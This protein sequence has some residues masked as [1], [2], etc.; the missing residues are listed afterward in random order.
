MGFRE[1]EEMLISDRESILEVVRGSSDSTVPQ[2]SVIMSAYNAERF[3]AQ[4]IESILAQTFGDFELIIVNDGSRDTTQEIIERY[5][6]QDRRIAPQSLPHNAGINHARNVGLS[7]ANGTYIALMDADD[8]SLPERFE[9]QVRFLDRHPEVGIVGGAMIIV[10]ENNIPIGERR[11]PTN[12]ASIRQRLFYYC[13]FCHPCIMVR[14]NVVLLTGSYDVQYRGTADYDL[15]FRIGMMTRFANLDDVLLHYRVSPGSYS[16]LQKKRMEMETIAI[17]R[18]YFKTY[19]NSLTKRMYH[20]LHTLSLF[21]IPSRWKY[22]LYF[23]IRET[24]V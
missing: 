17:R 9:K 21:I 19:G 23:K 2:V 20:A 12:D 11:Y 24:V 4:A 1:A 8:I 22:W 5:A 18:K 13:P 10:D 6:R 3:I 7:L 14:K 16:V 15:F